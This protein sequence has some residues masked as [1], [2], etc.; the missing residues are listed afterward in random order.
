[1]TF[2]PLHRCMNSVFDIGVCCKQ[3]CKPSFPFCKVQRE[4]ACIIMW[5]DE[6]LK[7]NKPFQEVILC[8][9]ACPFPLWNWMLLDVMRIHEL[10]WGCFL[11]PSDLT[12][13]T[14]RHIKFIHS[15]PPSSPSFGVSGGV[16]W[17]AW[18]HRGERER[19]GN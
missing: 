7:V 17:L 5:C 19:A 14:L 16:V 2:C 9:T 4:S 8:V 10:I 6:M 1:M 18:V 3:P 11:D 12:H 15:H 13:V